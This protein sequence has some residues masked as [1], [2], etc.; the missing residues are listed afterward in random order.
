MTLDEF[1]D[2][3]IRLGREHGYHPTAFIGMRKEQ[4][5]RPAI[6]RLV[7]SSEPK[8]G[9]KRMQEL[10]MVEWTLKSA[11]MKYPDE[12]SKEA[13]IYAQAR[14]EGTLDAEP[15]ALLDHIRRVHRAK[16]RAQ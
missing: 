2:E 6:E 14:L 11:V 8:A 13:K 7:K 5:T 10:G 12:F 16:D 3:G 4:G 1:V 9:F 15:H